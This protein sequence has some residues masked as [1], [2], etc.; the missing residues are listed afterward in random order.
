MAGSKRKNNHDKDCMDCI[1]S[2]INLTVPWYLMAAHA[3]YDG[4]DPILSDSV[5]DKLAQKMLKNWDT[6]EHMHKDCITKEDL[7]AGTFLGKYPS[8]VESA[9]LALR[10][11]NG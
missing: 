11:K 6:I 2:S 4:D 5:F 1:D 3:Y 7:Q 9:V 10:G 8:R